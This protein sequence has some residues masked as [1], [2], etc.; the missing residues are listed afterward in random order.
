MRPDGDAST[1]LSMHV[2]LQEEEC[3]RCGDMHLTDD[4]GYCGLCHLVTQAE[5]VDGF[6]EL[7]AYL[8]RWAEFRDWEAARDATRAG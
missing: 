1:V 3:I 6:S 5:L 7:R 8:T 4:L 2:P